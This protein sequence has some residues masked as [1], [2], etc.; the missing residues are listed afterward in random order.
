MN[1][2]DI[3][4]TAE[5]EQNSTEE[6]SSSCSS[7]SPV[8]VVNSND[9]SNIN[10]QLNDDSNVNVYT[11]TFTP[12]SEIPFVDQSIVDSFLN[13]SSKNPGPILNS[14]MDDSNINEQSNDDSNVNVFE[15]IKFFDK[16]K[17]KQDDDKQMEKQNDEYI[18][19]VDRCTRPRVRKDFLKTLRE[20]Y[21]ECN[22]DRKFYIYDEDSIGKSDES[23]KNLNAKHN[24]QE[25][26]PQ[27]LINYFVSMA[28]PGQCVFMSAEIPHYCAF[29]FPAVAL[30]LG[31][32]N[33]H[34]L[35]KAYQLLSSAKHWRVRRTLASSIHEIAMILGEELTATD[36]VPIYDGF[37]KD[38]DEVRIGVLKHFATFLKILKPVDRCQYLSRLSDFLA[39]DNEWNWRFREELATQLLEIVSLFSPSDVAQSIAP[40]SFQLLVDKVAAVR[41]I[42]LELVR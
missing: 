23:C 41:T 1:R 21:E 36:L 37:I 42:A 20:K 17:E 10:E 38:L 11:I 8:P 35:K 22:L 25:I 3:L 18:S 2:K 12:L 39:T 24:K 19:P 9:N 27:E 6:N 14:N 29:S 28:D 4:K 7:E 40:L 34:Y 33:W 31:K 5:I 15:M 16:Q 30:T 13:S 32:E 26:V